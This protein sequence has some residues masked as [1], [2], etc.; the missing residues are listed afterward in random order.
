ML[1]IIANKK[2]KKFIN[3]N[4]IHEV[5]RLDEEFRQLVPDDVILPDF[6]GITSRQADIEKQLQ[7]IQRKKR[8]KNKN[9]SSSRI[10]YIIGNIDYK[11]VNLNSLGDSRCC[12]VLINYHLW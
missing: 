1:V 4:H 7:E 6:V 10:A 3:V 5:W 8:P 11:S 12:Y 2:R 9:R